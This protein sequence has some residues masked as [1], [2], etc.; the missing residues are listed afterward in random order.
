[1]GRVAGTFWVAVVAAGL[2]CSA[3]GFDAT[4]GSGGVGGG[5]VVV[6]AMSGGAGADGGGAG[7]PATAGAGGDVGVG[8]AA[9][10]AG[11][12][13]APA[14]CGGSAGG[15]LAGSSGRGAEPVGYWKEI[16]G[17]ADIA[18]EVIV[19]AWSA[20]R[21]DI[22]FATARSDDGGSSTR[23][24]SR[25]L[26][27]TAG[28]WSEELVVDLDPVWLPPVSVSGT[29]PDDVW[30]TG[31]NH[32]Y[33]RDAQGWQMMPDEEWAPQVV[34]AP[35]PWAFRAVA[36][37]A[38]DDVW[39]LAPKFLL[40]REASG[41][42]AYVIHDP[43]EPRTYMDVVYTL[44]TL[45]LGQGGD[46]WASGTTDTPGNTMDPAFTQHDTGG[47][48]L[49]EDLGLYLSEV[50]C[51]WPTSDGGFWYGAD[52]REYPGHYVFASLR[53]WDGHGYVDGITKTSDDKRLTIASIWGR[54]DADVW[55]AGSYSSWPDNLPALFHYDGSQWTELN[56]APTTGKAYVLVTGDAYATWAVTDQPRF[57]R[58]TPPLAH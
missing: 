12:A 48:W 20:G 43:P 57:F 44:W 56:H 45:W 6:P 53:H 9:G 25:L 17:P 3:A 33:H 7:A 15:G 18:G 58:F 41:W 1:M 10:V 24:A 40:H 37:R 47:S 26:R 19:S 11:A 14:S 28:T 51:A 5:F 46:V 23:T 42:S 49:R 36:A 31:N 2:G 34:E 55:A 50:D 4:P 52:M 29:G 54:A 22:F 27:W 30:A 8:G 21:D 32:I 35:A 38:A 39:F 13:G 16:P